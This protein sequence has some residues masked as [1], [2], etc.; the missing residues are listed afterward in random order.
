MAVLGTDDCQIAMSVTVC[1]ILIPFPDKIRITRDSIFASGG[2]IAPVVL[3]PTS[4][5]VEAARP[6]L[7]C[8]TPPPPPSQCRSDL[9]HGCRA[10]QLMVQNGTQNAGL[11]EKSR[12]IP[13]GLRDERDWH[14]NA[15]QHYTQMTWSITQ[16]NRTPEIPGRL[17]EHPQRPYL[18]PIRSKF[19]WRRG[20]H[21]W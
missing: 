4:S 9:P 12:S 19:P 5:G 13:A 14:S 18:Q 21:H 6:P 1:P 3:A 8:R 15:D 20:Y 10:S 11:A 7:F 17:D 16:A 2:P